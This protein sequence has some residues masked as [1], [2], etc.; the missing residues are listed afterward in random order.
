MIMIQDSWLITGGCG[1][2]GVNLIDHILK[3]NRDSKIRVLDNLSVG[4]RS[5]LLEV[6][7]FME[8]ESLIL[9]PESSSKVELVVADIRNFDSCLNVCK[10]IDV[11]VHLAAS[12]GVSTSV[13]N[14]RED[15]DVNVI[16]TFNMLEASRYNGVKKFIFASSGAPLGETEPPIHEEN[17]PKPVSPYGASKLAGE[18]YCSAYY[19]TFKLKT[20]LLRFSNV[21]GPR[22]EYKDSV[23]AKFFKQALANEPLEVYGDGNQTRDFIYIY[24]LINAIILASKADTGGEVFQIATYKETTVNEISEAVKGLVE[25]ETGKNVDIIYGE[26]RIGDVKRN[27]SDISKAKKIL[28]F[29]PKYDLL[30]GLRETFKYFVKK[31]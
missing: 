5:N 28:G 4:T 20:I 7:D 1:F 10:G 31:N 12:T 15:M 16:G 2:I 8:I 21:Y 23:V 13:K 18:G 24:D 29:E 27:F 30:T 25:K 26:P 17:A 22:S 9:N 11:V 6:C 19:R 3:K 14:P